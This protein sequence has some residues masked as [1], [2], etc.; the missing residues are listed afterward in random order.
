MPEWKNNVHFVLVEPEEAGNVGASAR[1]LKNMGFGNLALVNPPALTDEARWFAHLALDVLD[2]A[3]VHHTL[4]DAIK[5]MHLVVGTTRRKGKKRGVFR[6]IEE[7][8]EDVASLAQG[9]RVAV[10]FGREKKGLSNREAGECGLL[11]SIPANPE[12][13]SLNLSHAVMVVAYELARAGMKLTGSPATERNPV[14]HGELDTLYG[15]F[16]RALKLLDF[17]RRGSRDPAASTLRQLRHVI[18]RADITR[19]ELDMFH[20]MCSQIE[21]R[22][23]KEG[24]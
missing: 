7:G 13:P 17:P 3:T 19:Q 4:K 5:D 12:Q 18:G 22:L 8:M 24:T 6:N 9:R 11:F 15:R 1:A 14:T 20:G 2:E 10:L 21:K 16:S 23:G